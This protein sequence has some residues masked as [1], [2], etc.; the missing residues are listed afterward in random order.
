MFKKNLTNWNQYPLID[1]EVILPSSEAEC[2]GA[3]KQYPELISRGMGRSYGDAS[4]GN[5]VL[6][7]TAMNRIIELDIQKKIMIV[8]AGVSID[9]ILKQIVPSG[10]F[11]PVVPGTC[12]VSIGG[13]IA[14]DIHGKNHHIDGTFTRHVEWIEIID[15]SLQVV[16]CSLNENTNLFKQTCGGMGISG[17]ILRACLKLTKIETSFIKFSNIPFF[18]LDELLQ[19]F[20]I[21]KSSKYI[22][23]WLDVF[24]YSEKSL[25][26]ILMLGEQAEMN[27]LSEHNCKRP[28]SVHRSPKVSI[29]KLFP[30]FLLN[31]FTI[32]LFNQYHFFVNKK[33]FRNQI[34]H[35][36]KFFFPL[37]RIKNWNRLYGKSGFIQYQCL[38]PANSSGKKALFEILECCRINGIVSFLSVLK[39]FGEGNPDAN[40]SF[41]APGYT[42]S[43]DFKM[44]FKLFEILDDLDKIVENC[45]G[46]LY[47]A[48]DA[49]MGRKFFERTYP[50]PVKS[51][52]FVS[53]LTKRLGLY[54]PQK[55]D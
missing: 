9:E 20:E 42:L 40:M 28:L 13:A 8:E 37:D 6:D 25:N 35:Y 7:C 12:F 33:P 38:V 11:L 45:G 27:D 2:I 52:R 39:A 22:V 15:E 31:R 49:R 51:N 19:S 54:K 3:L 46:K 32:N 36:S 34:L 14:A 17:V 47:L 23:A 30:S 50:N 53:L 18:S 1:S 44:N 55:N 29:P 43:M 41:P 4:L 5:V 24:S 48:K 10:L 26:S 21:Y 16:R